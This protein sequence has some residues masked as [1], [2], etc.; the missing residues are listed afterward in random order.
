MKLAKRW[1]KVLA[2]CAFALAAGNGCVGIYGPDELQWVNPR[3]DGYYTGIEPKFAERGN[4]DPL[5]RKFRVAFL[6][7][8]PHPCLYV[9][10]N[11]DYN[12]RVLFKKVFP[13]S[14]AYIAQYS[15]RPGYHPDTGELRGAVEKELAA[16]TFCVMPFREQAVESQAHKQHLE[17]DSPAS[18]QTTRALGPALYDKDGA[19]IAEYLANTY[20]PDKARSMSSPID[21]A[22]LEGYPS[23]TWMRHLNEEL[24]ARCPAVFSADASAFPLDVWIVVAFDR[25]G[26]ECFARHGPERIRSLYEA[27][28]L[29]LPEHATITFHD[30]VTQGALFRADQAYTDPYDAIAAAVFKLSPEQLENLDPANPNDHIASEG[31]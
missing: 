12:D 6:H 13:D 15:G 10:N 9:P 22:F 23:E 19:L 30:T 29:G 7:A 20:D 27:W 18:Y 1:E 11:M 16:S 21:H 28:L 26:R 14:C 8:F 17:T 31:K 3:P 5:E 24:A 4:P 25:G 2:V